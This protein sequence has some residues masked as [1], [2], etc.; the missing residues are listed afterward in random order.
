MNI[1]PLLLQHSLSTSLA[2][3][4]INIFEM[5][6]INMIDNLPSTIDFLLNTQAS[7]VQVIINSD[8]HFISFWISARQATRVFLPVI[9]FA[10]LNT[11]FWLWRIPASSNFSPLAITRS[12][13]CSMSSGLV[14]IVAVMVQVYSSFL[15]VKTGQFYVI[16][17]T[18]L[19][20]LLLRKFYIF[21]SS[22]NIISFDREA[23]GAIF[24]GI[25]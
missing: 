21:F 15:L 13:Y 2:H 11:A 1:L 3:S 10:A 5:D 4:K 25:H 8:F 18:L 23:F 12:L 9:D 17:R 22:Q 6:C 7:F 16:P 20:P 24:I 19:L 14:S